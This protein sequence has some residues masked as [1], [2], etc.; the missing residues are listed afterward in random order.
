MEALPPIDG[1]AVQTPRTGTATVQ[2]EPMPGASGPRSTDASVQWSAGPRRLALFGIPV[3][4]ALLVAGWKLIAPASD[5]NAH[6]V[7]KF[8][9][10]SAD[11]STLAPL[12]QVLPEPRLPAVIAPIDT[13]PA[14]SRVA[15]PPMESNTIPAPSTVATAAASVAPASGAPGRLGF[16]IS[17]WGE[18]YVDGRKRGVTPPLAE[19]TLP[20]GTYKI[21][22][23]NTTFPPHARTIELRADSTL[24]IKHR[25]Q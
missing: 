12:K 21:E 5:G 24:R 8:A 2:L 1:K 23:R 9:S 15:E 20:P 7:A 18:V 25:F 19:L 4:L 16:A 10:S 11:T 22:I 17:P 13:R 14:A 3:A 6:A